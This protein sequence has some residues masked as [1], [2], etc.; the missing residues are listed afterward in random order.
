MEVVL[1]SRTCKEPKR[2]IEYDGYVFTKDSKT[3][4]YL[5][6]KPID[7]KRIRLHRYVWEKHNGEILKG[8]QIHHKD[9]SKD[10]N[11]IDNLALIPMSKH[12]KYHSVK[13][14]IDHYT[15]KKERFIS[16]AIPK[17]AEW[18][19]SEE[20]KEWHKEHGKR[21]WES[22]KEK[23]ARVII[24]IVCGKEKETYYQGEVK[25]CSKACKA[26]D[27]RMRFKEAGRDYEYGRSKNR[28]N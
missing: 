19:G 21:V 11:E 26:K 27:L 3:G 22:L 16:N 17:A 6:A 12:L 5:S 15:E 18:H 8:Y 4:Y 2:Q 14:V 28:K 1:M 7:G 20:G 24:C 13:D 10:N 23:P 9:H 25:F